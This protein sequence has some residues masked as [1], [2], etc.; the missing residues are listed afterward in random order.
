MAIV[1]LFDQ[2]RHFYH[3]V[4]TV[5]VGERYYILDNM[6]DDVLPDTRLTDY[7]PLYS[8]RG[9]RGYLHGSRVQDAAVA[10][11]TVPLEKVTPG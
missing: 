1:V 7:L 5:A 2:K 8:I 10:A 11:N 3:A 9:K 4:L 6:R